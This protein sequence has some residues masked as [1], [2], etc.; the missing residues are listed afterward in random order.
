MCTSRMALQFFHSSIF[1]FL[2]I[3]SRVEH[4]HFLLGEETPVTPL[5]TLLGEARKHH[6]VEFAH[7]IAKAFE[8]AAHDAVLARVNLNAHLFAVCV[9]SVTDSIGL[10]VAI[11]ERDAF[12]NLLHVGSSQVLV[13]EDM[14]NLLLQELRMSEF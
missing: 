9:G 7:L 13:K 10:D 11:F 5:D 12:S 1:L 4:G 8:D 3:M 2:F 6:A 14:V